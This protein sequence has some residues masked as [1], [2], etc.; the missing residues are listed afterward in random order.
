MITTI[1]YSSGKISFNLPTDQLSQTISQP[2]NITWTDIKDPSPDDLAVLDEVFHFHPLAIEYCIKPPTSPKIVFFGES[3]FIIFFSVKYDSHNKRLITVPLNIFLKK[4]HLVTFHKK[5]VR[6]VNETFDVIKQNPAETLALGAD[7]TLYILLDLISEKY[8]DILDSLNNRIE[9]VEDKVLQ[10]ESENVSKELFK[11]KKEMLHLRKI[12]SPQRDSISRLI[13]EATPIIKS[14][15]KIYFHDVYDKLFKVS[16]TITTCVDILISTQELFFSVVSNKTNQV[17]KTLAVI[18]TVFMP[19]TLITGIYGM[20]F[21]H[22]PGL[23]SPYGYYSTLILMVLI[24]GTALW[25]F[26][27]KNWF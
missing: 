7:F 2:E 15:V 4:N 12:T 11:L 8:L 6:G 21:K 14:N 10:N 25:I 5:D 22:I 17:V 1:L 13:R 3:I 19:L 20:N 23:D 26:K 18:A 9:V 24:C 27:R 16:E